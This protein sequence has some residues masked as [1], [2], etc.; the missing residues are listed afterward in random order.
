MDFFIT[1]GYIICSDF[2]QQKSKN[3]TW[4]LQMSGGITAAEWPRFSNTVLARLFQ[5]NFVQRHS[6][7]Q[8]LPEE[9]ANALNPL[10]A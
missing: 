2:V 4:K 8:C 5:E 10:P 3:M 9:K 6:K 7:Q 1:S